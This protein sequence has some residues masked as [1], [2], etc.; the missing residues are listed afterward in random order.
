[1]NEEIKRN[2]VKNIS[3]RHDI[4]DLFL[5]MFEKGQKKFLFIGSPGSGKTR[6]AKSFFEIFDD[7]YTTIT[8][9]DVY[10]SNERMD[11]YLLKNKFK[12]SVL[13]EELSCFSFKSTPRDVR[14]TKIIVELIKNVDFIIATTIDT[15]NIDPALVDAFS[16]GILYFKPL[17]YVG[18]LNL[19]KSFKKDDINNPEIVEQFYS[20][21]DENEREHFVRQFSG[22]QP[23]EILMCKNISIDSTLS[24]IGGYKD[25]LKK[26]RFLI[27]TSLFE[28]EKFK[29]IGVLPPRGI[30]LVGPSGTGKTLIAKSFGLAAKVSFFNVKST[31]IISKEL[32]GSEK[33]LHSIFERA[34]ASSPSIIL[35]DDID[36]I[37]PKRTFGKTLNDASDRLLTTLLIETDGLEGRDD[38]VIILGTTSRFDSLDPAIVRPGRFDY[39]IDIPLP[40]ED[41]KAEIFDI[42]TKD[43]PIDNREE[44]KKIV[45]SSSNK[46]TGADIEGIIKEAAM[47]A[48][49][50][51][52]AAQSVDTESFIEALNSLPKKIQEQQQKEYDYKTF[53]AKK[54]PKRI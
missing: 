38:G 49:R 37:A 3:S 41:E 43:I 54:R 25:I 18:R 39:I 17:D 51:S 47:I 20:I 45:L 15:T 30:L 5:S 23:S 27:L 19:F 16:G 32:G 48:L 12:G 42:Y 22:L 29:N 4:I 11:N 8:S 31:E 9:C 46:F 2:L 13:L 1:M 36:S 34:R 6:F 24:N 7:E 33:N 28:A 44:A 50:K 14:V 21:N 40:T 53:V 35:F 26:L 52:L 10:N